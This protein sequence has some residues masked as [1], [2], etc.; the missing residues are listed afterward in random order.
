MKRTS[1]LA[2]ASIL[3]LAWFFSAPGCS[4]DNKAA[5]PSDASIDSNAPADDSGPGVTPPGDGGRVSK[6]KDLGS[7]C[8]TSTECKTGLMCDL[9]FANGL[10]T[11]AC[12]TDTECAGK[13]VSGACIDNLCFATCVLGAVTD[14]GRPR[15]ACKNRSFACVDVPGRTAMVCLP[16]GDAGSTDAGLPSDGGPTED[17]SDAESVDANAGDGETH[18]HGDA[19]IEGGA[20]AASGG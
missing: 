16:G 7:A 11:K 18:G 9:S 19:E 10:C 8:T 14:A 6:P 20:D 5:G 17:G 2:K 3:P 15:A 13:R 1:A 4:G 12:T